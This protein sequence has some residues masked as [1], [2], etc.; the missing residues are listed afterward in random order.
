MMDDA[1]QTTNDP[2]KTFAKAHRAVTANRYA[3][4]VAGV[5]AA[6]AVVI[7]YLGYD[8]GTVV[9]LGGVLVGMLLLFVFQTLLTV[10]SRA[11]VLAGL[12]LV[13]VVTLF[14][15][16]F[17]VFTA[18]AVAVRWP[19]VWANVLGI[20]DASGPAPQAKL[21][22]E[23][24]ESVPAYSCGVGEFIVADLPWDDPENG[25]NVRETP[26]LW[27]TRIG[28]IPS[29]A[30]GVMVDGKCESGWCPVQCNTMKGWSAANYLKHKSLAARVPVVSE[31]MPVGQKL[32]PS[33]PKGIRMRNGPSQ[34]CSPVGLIPHDTR[35]ILEHSCQPSPI[36][37]DIWC[38]VTINKISGWVRGGTLRPAP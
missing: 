8:K 15:T 1:Q 31:A 10:D 11:V 4:G 32:G 38:Y 28:V 36:G 13:W 18:T 6:G 30:T 17:L 16:T 5:A 35:E 24:N 9:M 21:C 22:G 26:K 19:I 37:R 29:N 25:L 7:H 20:I 34:S 33:E 27:G 12:C 3:V 2:Q 23:P 14:F